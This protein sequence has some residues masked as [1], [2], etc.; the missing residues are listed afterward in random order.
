MYV[1]LLGPPGAGKGS[2]A[3]ELAREIGGVHISTGEMLRAALRSGTPYGLKAREYMETGRLVPDDIVLGML[4]ER[5]EQDDARENVVLDGFPRNEAQALALDE[6][7]RAGG[8]RVDC[9]VNIEVPEEVLVQR[10]G[11][12]WTC[13]SCGAIYHQAFHPPRRAGVCDA[14]GGELRQRL[15][16]HDE[17]V[18]QRLQVYFT[19]TAPVVEFYRQAGRLAE[20]N[21]NQAREAVTRDLLAAVQRECAAERQAR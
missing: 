18:K 15:D 9:A 7:L 3:P 5:L 4:M 12:R 16:D 8:K 1:V 19:E 10:L 20:V 13:S 14:C 21:G 11:G 6:T 2:Q 17:A